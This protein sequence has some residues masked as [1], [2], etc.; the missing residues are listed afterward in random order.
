MNC[1]VKMK[2]VYYIELQESE[3]RWFRSFI[4][5]YPGDRLAEPNTDK[6]IRHQMFDMLTQSLGIKDKY[7]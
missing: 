4:Q 5:N 3:L 6:K 1:S 7:E 2:K